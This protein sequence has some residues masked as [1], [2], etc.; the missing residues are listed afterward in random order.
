MKHRSGILLIVIVG[1]FLTGC[2]MTLPMQQ[3]SD[4][5]QAIAAARK[6][7][8]N[9]YAP[10]NYAKA[11]ALLQEA[12]TQMN[13]GSYDAAERLAI[14]AQKAADRARQKSLLMSHSSICYPKHLMMQ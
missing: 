2:A 10:R 3:M 1:L 5:R 12:Q 4:A 6:A 11:L 9:Q 13:V 7:H 8:A 14:S